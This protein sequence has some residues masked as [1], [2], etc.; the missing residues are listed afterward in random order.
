[1]KSEEKQRP[2]KGRETK[3]SNN[4]TISVD[5]K[6]MARSN[7][8]KTCFELSLHYTLSHQRKVFVL[9]N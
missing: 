8:A 2:S 6:T 9:K 1:M 3:P 5:R 7:N 4:N